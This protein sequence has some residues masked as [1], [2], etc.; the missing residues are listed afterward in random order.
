MK[1]FIFREKEMQTDYH[2]KKG[3]PPGP[4]DSSRMLSPK[5]IEGAVLGFA[6]GDA[7]GVP[8]EFMSREQLKRNPVAGLSLIHISPAEK[9]EQRTQVLPRMREIQKEWQ[10]VLKKRQA[11]R[12]RRLRW[13]TDFR[14]CTQQE[15]TPWSLI[16]EQK[17][18][19]S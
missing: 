17:I 14:R 11:V 16:P 7:L 15:K 8:A 18:V 6:V 1:I 5:D 9:T 19:F 13:K 3:I 10:R 12:N 4:S 2:Q